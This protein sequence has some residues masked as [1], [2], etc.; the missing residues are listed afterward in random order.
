MHF[1]LGLIHFK[2]YA[3]FYHQIFFNADKC[4]HLYQLNLKFIFININIDINIDIN[5]DTYVIILCNT[6][7]TSIKY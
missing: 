1:S 4:L 2:T 6:S 5:S 3:H 7:K